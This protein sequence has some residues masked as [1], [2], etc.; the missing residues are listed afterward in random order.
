MLHKK[1]TSLSMVDN[2]QKVVEYLM[3]DVDVTLYEFQKHFFLVM[4]FTLRE[5]RRAPDPALSGVRGSL[6]Q[7][8]PFRLDS[9]AL[10]LLQHW[11][12]DD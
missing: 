12:K 6:L 9:G 8:H 7:L 4:F 1:M 2:F 10:R 11:G 3:K 5:S